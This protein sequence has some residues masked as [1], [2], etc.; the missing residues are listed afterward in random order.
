LVAELVEAPFHNSTKSP[1]VVKSSSQHQIPP[2]VLDDQNGGNDY[3]IDNF[4]NPTDFNASF[5]LSTLS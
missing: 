4:G 3:F 5:A 1:A 2:A